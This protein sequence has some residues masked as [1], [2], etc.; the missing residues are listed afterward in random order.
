MYLPGVVGRT[1]SGKSTLTLGILRILELVE[2]PTGKLGKIEIDNIDIANIGL[3]E[4]RKKVTIIPQDP[5]LFTE[6]IRFN[7]DPFSEMSDEEIVDALKKTHMWDSLELSD[8][9]KKGTPQEIEEKLKMKVTE[10]GGNFSL[11]QRQLLCMARA[12][13]RKPKVLLLDEATASIDEM[14]DHLIQKMIRSEFTDTTVITIAHRLNTIIQYDK[15]M[16][17]DKGKIVEFDAPDVLLEDEGGAFL[18]LIREQGADF[19][20]RMKNLARNKDSL[21]EEESIN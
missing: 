11:G 14:T 12:L 7:I 16:V 20:E 13:I 19:E 15:I 21:Q 2:D 5:M 8:P 18:K 4:L 3:H 17:L 6:T 9:S 10:G 1:G